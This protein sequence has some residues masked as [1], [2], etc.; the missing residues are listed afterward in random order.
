MINKQSSDDYDP[1]DSH[2]F[3]ESRATGSTPPKSAMAVLDTH[4][5]GS[6][7]APLRSS[8]G[9]IPNSTASAMPRFTC[10]SKWCMRKEPLRSVKTCRRS[11]DKHDDHLR[12]IW[13]HSPLCFSKVQD[14]NSPED[15]HH[16]IIWK[17]EPL[18]G[19]FPDLKIWFRLT[20][21]RFVKGYEG[22]PRGQLV[23]DF[24]TECGEERQRSL[25]TVQATDGFWTGSLKHVNITWF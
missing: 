20:R 18:R 16:I 21:C 22:W 13:I 19:D 8:G 25:G 4:N 12:S 6:S 5:F 11:T 9:R 23:H 14:R 15:D 2:R 7:S 24:T 3:P 17:P 10:F 1:K